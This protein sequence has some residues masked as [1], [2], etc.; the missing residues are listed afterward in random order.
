MR[1]R[2]DEKTQADKLPK[3][4]KTDN[5]LQV[6]ERGTIDIFFSVQ[7]QVDY[8]HVNI[9]PSPSAIP[10]CLSRR[11]WIIPPRAMPNVRTTQS[12]WPKCRLF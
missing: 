9:P 8:P 10:V 5:V 6:S 1:K 11:Q 3:N 12:I 4:I 7:S 2:K